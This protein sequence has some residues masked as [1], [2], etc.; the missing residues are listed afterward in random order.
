MGRKGVPTI[1]DEV[2]IG[3]DATLIGKIKVGSHV[4][5]AANT[6]VIDDLM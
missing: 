5:I 4:K 1:G 2:Y 3:T 6:L